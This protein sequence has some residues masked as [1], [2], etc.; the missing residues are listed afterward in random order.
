MVVVV[1]LRK[2]ASFPIS[3][4]TTRNRSQA[5]VP[6]GFTHLE[7]QPYPTLWEMAVGSGCVRSCISRAI[8]FQS[9]ASC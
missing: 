2:N 4:E 5:G 8:V 9:P 1:D 6:Q 3:K 7:H